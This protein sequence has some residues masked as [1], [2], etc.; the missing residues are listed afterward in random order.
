[1]G[2]GILSGVGAKELMVSTLGVLYNAPEDADGNTSD[3]SLSTAIRESGTTPAAALS[4]LVFALLYFP[5]MA[6]IAAIRSESGRWKY[7]IFT[8]A[9][10][11][12]VAYV[13]AFVVYR[14]ALLFL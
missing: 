3:S 12:A 8:A 4:Y 9:Y 13:M 14:L 7:A 10:T 2:V 5:C 6:T 11:T 1:M